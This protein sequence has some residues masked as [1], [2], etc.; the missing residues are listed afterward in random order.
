MLKNIAEKIKFVESICIINGATQTPYIETKLGEMKNGEKITSVNTE[1]HELIIVIVVETGQ[2][3]YYIRNKTTNLVIM[4]VDYYTDFILNADWAT[5]R[6]E[7]EHY[8]GDQLVDEET[9]DLHEVDL[10]DLISRIWDKNHCSIVTNVAVSEKW[11]EYNED[12][13][14]PFILNIRTYESADELDSFETKPFERI[15]F[16]G[17]IDRYLSAIDELPFF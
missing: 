2:V 3:R 1:S 13:V 4:I 7:Y 10:E 11:T 9:F 12:N 8:K 14:F 15:Q 17:K 16:V 5:L 6:V